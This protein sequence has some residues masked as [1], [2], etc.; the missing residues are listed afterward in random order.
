LC[1]SKGASEGLVQEIERV[2][3]EAHREDQ[4]EGAVNFAELLDSQTVRLRQSRQREAESIASIS[5]RIAAELEKESLVAALNQQIA[6][7]RNLIAARMVPDKMANT[8][9]FRS[10]ARDVASPSMCAGRSV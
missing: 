10:G 5:E 1:S 6:Q 3:F 7:K 9:Q 2:I 8:S 4:R